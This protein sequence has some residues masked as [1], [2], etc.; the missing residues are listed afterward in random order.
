MLYDT[1]KAQQGPFSV[2]SF[3]GPEVLMIRFS[4]DGQY[5][6]LSTKQSKMLVFHAYNLNEVAKF[7]DYE[8]NNLLIEGNF[9]PDS[10]CVIQ[11]SEDGKVHI[12]EIATQEEIAVYEGH[13]K[14]CQFVKFSPKHVLFASTCKNL[15]FWLPRLLMPTQ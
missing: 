5:M 14:A 11:G 10:R 1:E 7:T 8:N 15:V 9:T 6:L 2:Q 4:L 13:V 12:W 3:K